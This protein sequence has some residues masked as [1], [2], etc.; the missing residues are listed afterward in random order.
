MHKINNDCYLFV[1]EVVL[2]CF[3]IE[4][5]KYF[6]PKMSQSHNI[7]GA[8]NKYIV[9]SLLKIYYTMLSCH[10]TDPAG[11][12]KYSFVWMN[13]SKSLQTS[14]DHYTCLAIN[15]NVLRL[16]TKMLRKQ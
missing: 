6:S 14:Y 12:L 11:L 10:G 3:I 4:L 16:L 2:G 7:V 8:Q 5:L 1:I 13:A 9:F 15:K